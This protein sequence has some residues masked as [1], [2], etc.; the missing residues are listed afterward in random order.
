MNYWI[1]TIHED[2]VRR[3]EKGGFTQA[4]H[5][6]NTT[7]GRVKKGDWIVFYSPK[8]ATEGK[9]L[10][11]F[12]AIGQIIDSES[13][14]VAMSEDFHPW[15]RR[16]DFYTCSSAPIR[17]LIPELQFIIDKTHWGFRFRFGMF[18]IL[19]SDFKIIQQAMSIGSK[20]E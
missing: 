14:Q 3:G 4:N 15:R 11:H 7:L 20:I 6:K 19:D 18:Q 13:Y 12:T 9:P 8:T 10:Q 2:H 1:N 5:G 16:L 17:P